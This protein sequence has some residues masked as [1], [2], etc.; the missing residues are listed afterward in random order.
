MSSHV[1]GQYGYIHGYI[2]VSIPRSIRFSRRRR[3]ARGSGALA[4]REAARG[5]TSS[6]IS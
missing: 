3:D 6:D 5:T 1:I 4:K 2:V